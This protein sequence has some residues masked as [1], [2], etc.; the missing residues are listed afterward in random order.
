MDGSAFVAG[1]GMLL[2]CGELADW[3]E[4]MKKVE[5]NRAYSVIKQTWIM[6]T[7]RYRERI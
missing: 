7:K 6:K 4:R 1:R 3:T 5:L 2:S